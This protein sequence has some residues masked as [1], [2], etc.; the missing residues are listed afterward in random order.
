MCPFGVVHRVC[1][2]KTETAGVGR[3]RRVRGRDAKVRA[4]V[5]LRGRDTRRVRDIFSLSVSISFSFSLFKF[6]PK[7][8]KP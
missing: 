6:S 2:Q 7:S 1:R 8:P 4:S 5:I 3:A